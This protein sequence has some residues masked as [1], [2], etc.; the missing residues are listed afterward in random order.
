MLFTPK[1]SPGSPRVVRAA[2][3]AALAA[4]VL[5]AGALAGGGRTHAASAQTG[6]AQLASASHGLIVAGNAP[7][8]TAASAVSPP[9]I[10]VPVYNGCNMDSTYNGTSNTLGP[11]SAFLGGWAD[12]SKLGDALTVGYPTSALAQSPNGDY[13]MAGTFTDTSGN[14]WQCF[15]VSLN[16]D[17]QGQKEFPPTSA[18]F[19]AFGFVPVTATVHLIQAGPITAVVYRDNGGTLGSANPFTAVSTAQVS[20]QLTNVKVN[21]T[22]LDVGSDCHTA[23]T[24]YSPGNPINPHEL[25]TVGGQNAGDSGPLYVFELSG[26][27]AGTATIPP[28]TGCVTPGGENLDSLLT[29]SVSGSGNFVKID[30]GVPCLVGA[31]L[32]AKPDSVNGPP[33]VPEILPLWTVK[34]G[35]TFAATAPATISLPTSLAVGQGIINIGCNSALNATVPDTVGPLRGDTATVDWSF[36]GCRDQSGNQWTIVQQAPVPLDAEFLIQ[37]VTSTEVSGIIFNVSGPDG[38]TAQ[39][40]GN[41]EP[42]YAAGTLTLRAATRIERLFPTNATSACPKFIEPIY[43]AGGLPGNPPGGNPNLTPLSYNFTPPF[44]ISSP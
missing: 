13:V 38:C 12:A 30:Q 20:A 39:L 2:A 42:T 43:L 37:G 15:K 19:L 41:L 10:N 4:G 6:S 28:F 24:L 8:Q 40:T 29:S 33:G 14:S 21:G 7:G 9:P 22:P 16:L 23:G 36:T 27:L 18:T 3:V 44:D 5:V 26:S 11:F 1:I 31:G 32:C 17:Y 35:G 34:N 25:V